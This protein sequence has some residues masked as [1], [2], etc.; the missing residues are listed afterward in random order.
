[1]ARPPLLIRSVIAG[2]RYLA[3]LIFFAVGLTPLVLL[4]TGVAS[5][6]GL[7][8]LVSVFLVAFGPLSAINVF[9]GY[10][11]LVLSGNQL[12]IWNH[13]F[14]PKRYDLWP[15]G[16]AYAVLHKTR[17]S[18]TMELAFRSAEAETAHRA[19]EKFPYAPEH[20]DADL[21]IP[22]GNF[23]GRDTDKA[24]ALAAEINQHR[25]LR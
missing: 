18:L 17:R 16:E 9:L 14:W 1:M 7:I 12:S 3:A 5:P 24:D 2:R 4:S 6:P 8:V 13:P 11:R 25:S 22:I 19:A 21:A 23:V 10:P 20:E 15:Y